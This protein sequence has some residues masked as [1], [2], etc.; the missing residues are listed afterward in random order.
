[1]KP[2]AQLRWT[3]LFASMTI[4]TGCPGGTP[5]DN[6]NNG[7][8]CVTD[9]DCGGELSCIAGSCVYVEPDGVGDDCGGIQ[10][11]GCSEG[12]VCDM[13]A[14]NHCGADLMGTCVDNE[15]GMCTMEYNPV[16]G[17]DGQT[18]GNDCLRRAAFIALDRVGPCGDASEGQ[19][20]GGSFNTECAGN[21]VCDLSANN[22]C[23]E[24]LV[25]SC[26]QRIRVMCTR[27]WVPVCG[28]DGQT[29]GNDCERRAAFVAFG[30][31]GECTFRDNQR[32]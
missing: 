18:Y 28:C 12:L 6:N 29:Y 26:V 11:L 21:L 20:C 17:C 5:N 31:S 27:E 9:S 25:G 30:A 22:Q 3:I 15:T 1:M 32:I 7:P 4:L 23:A 19:Q 2:I 16:C 24:D 13:S 10:G 14:F 8:E